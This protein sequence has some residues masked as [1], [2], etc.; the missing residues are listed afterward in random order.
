[1]IKKAPSQVFLHNFK[2]SR[3]VVDGGIA[4]AAAA[5][6]VIKLMQSAST[7]VLSNL[8][9]MQGKSRGEGGRV[10]AGNIIIPIFFIC[11]SLTIMP[12]CQ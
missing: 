1:M 6:L 9:G 2:F 12:C 7:Q 8:L 10:F 4:A 11:K 5:T 3:F